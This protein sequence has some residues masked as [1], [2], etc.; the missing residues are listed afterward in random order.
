LERIGPLLLV[1]RCSDDFVSK[2]F[3]EHRPFLLSCQVGLEFSC[4]V[5]KRVK[6]FD[7]LKVAAKDIAS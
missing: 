4:F 7:E 3:C 1:K 5:G 2:M 6:I